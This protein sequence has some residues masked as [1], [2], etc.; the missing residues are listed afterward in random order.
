MCPALTR[1][2]SCVHPRAGQNIRK[3]IE[4]GFVIRKPTVIHSRSRVNRRDEAKR[5]GRHQGA[6]PRRRATLLLSCSV[7]G[8]AVAAAIVS[9]LL[10]LWWLFVVVV[11]SRRRHAVLCARV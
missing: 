10:S 3:L 9:S 7:P 2:A 1:V 6:C 8:R 5:K 11:L 4:D